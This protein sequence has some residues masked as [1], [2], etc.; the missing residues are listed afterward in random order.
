MQMGLLNYL[1]SQSYSGRE[2]SLEPPA[3]TA[4]GI[5]LMKRRPP[6]GTVNA[7]AARGDRKRDKTDEAAVLSTQTPP[8]A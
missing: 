7:D 5:K 3:V 8:A 6:E 1:E 2:G 4:S